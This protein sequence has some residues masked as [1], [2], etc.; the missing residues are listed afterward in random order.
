SVIPSLEI[1]SHFDAL[2]QQIG[3]RYSVES[4]LAKHTIYPF[5]APFLSKQR[6][7]EILWD[8]QGDGKGLYT[9][10]RMIAGGI[11]KKDG[12]YYCLQCAYCH[13]ARSGEPYSH[14]AY[15]L[16]FMDLCAHHYFQL[17]IYADEFTEH[18]R[19]NF[20]R[21]EVQKMDLSVIQ[22]VV[23]PNRFDIQVNLATM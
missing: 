5:Y 20:I 13:I 4:L 2:A 1:G 12:L 7:Q 17:K 16:Q 22:E 15:P 10:L 21:V 6:Q 3:N 19:I 11:C 9:R 23:Y 14:G 18:S 8:V